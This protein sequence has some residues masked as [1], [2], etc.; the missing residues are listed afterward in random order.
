MLLIHTFL[1]LFTYCT[2]S[3]YFKY[4]TCSCNNISREC[5]ATFCHCLSKARYAVRQTMKFM[6]HLSDFA[7][8]NE[9]NIYALSHFCTH[10]L[11]VNICLYTGYIPRCTYCIL[12]SMRKFGACIFAVNNNQASN[13]TGT[14][15]PI[16]PM[17]SS[18]VPLTM[19]HFPV[20]I[21]KYTFSSTV[22]SPVYATIR[23]TS[24]FPYSSIIT[25]SSFN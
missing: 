18:I 19:V 4:I 9:N 17:L 3:I 25:I 11:L 21:F 15:R 5:I 2:C 14:L 6:H 23:T 20:H 7:L 22:N 13:Q 12:L 8:S 1:H 10:R 16:W 24:T